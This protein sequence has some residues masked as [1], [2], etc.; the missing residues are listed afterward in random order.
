MTSDTGLLPVADPAEVRPTGRLPR[1]DGRVL[2]GAG[3]PRAAAERLPR[4]DRR[5]FE[6]AVR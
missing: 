6:E 2:D 1:A 5:A 4:T 3:S